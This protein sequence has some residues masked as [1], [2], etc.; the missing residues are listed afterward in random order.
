MD[1]ALDYLEQ[2]QDQHDY[3]NK[4]YA[5]ATI[6]A[7]SWPKTVAAVSESKDQH[8]QND[9]QQH[10]LTPLQPLMQTGRFVAR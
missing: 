8:E 9:Y 4:A 5:A 3:E 1:G 10:G 2:Q 7:I 6:V